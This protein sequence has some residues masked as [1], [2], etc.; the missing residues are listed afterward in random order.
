ML[1][2]LHGTITVE[3]IIFILE[4]IFKSSVYI[5]NKGYFLTVITF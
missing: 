3:K 5:K 2:V 1:K 4:V